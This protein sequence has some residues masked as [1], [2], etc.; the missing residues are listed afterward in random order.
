[1]SQSS[2]NNVCHFFLPPHA[3]DTDRQTVNSADAAVAHQLKNVLRL[4][5]GSMVKLLDGQGNMWLATIETIGRSDASFSLKEQLARA[6]TKCGVEIVSVLP[7]I[8]AQRFEWALEKLTELGVERICP[9]ATARCVV[10]LK[11]DSEGKEKRW[12]QI[13]KEASE[14]SERLQLP[15]LE[16]AR[17]LAE[18]LANLRGQRHC[19]L[20]LSERSDAPDMVQHL[21]ALARDNSLGNDSGERSS[22]P[23]QIILVSGPEGGFDDDEKKLI[24]AHHFQPVTLGNTILRSETAAILAAGIAKTIGRTLD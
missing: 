15:E 19:K 5:P 2:S 6:T 20:W 18:A 7:L 10:K 9:V 22:E 21:L 1:M 12:T 16:K 14:Q 3:F 17:G 11:D 23:M 8:K 13:V 24:A 4:K